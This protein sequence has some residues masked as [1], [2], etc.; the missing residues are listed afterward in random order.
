MRIALVGA[1]AFDSLEYNLQETFVHMG[2]E[3]FV[4]NERQVVPL[5]GRASRNV[6]AVASS[7]GLAPARW[8]YDRLVAKVIAYSP[9]LTV[10]T[11]R[12]LPPRFVEGLKEAIPKIP[13]VQINPDAI[14]GVERGYI[15]LSPFDAYFT[16]EP[17]LYL[18][19]KEKLCL[20]AHYLPESFN[21]RVHTKPVLPKPEC[22]AR[23]NVDLVVVATLYP[24]RIRFLE[25]L[26]SLLP[27][28]IRLQ[29]YGGKRSWAPTRLWDHHTGRSLSGPEKA[30]VFYGARVV[31]NNMHFAEADGV[32]CRFFEVLGSG[33]F[34]LCDDKPAVADLATPGTEVVTFRSVKEAAEKIQYYLAHPE[35]R[36]A[37]A[38]A[39]YERAIRSH[40][41]EHRI[42]SVLSL[43][44]MA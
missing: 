13:V 9:D 12:H 18:T 8:A 44:G 27:S 7:L 16:K 42:Q 34:M 14:T 21:P 24:Y 26:M 37:I 23:S 33:A 5:F 43:L 19:M 41:Y 38:Q 31:L 39:A 20:N 17:Q 40:T 15:F 29:I 10:V 30:D 28:R 1:E 11:Y 36:W 3:A 35:E 2:H 25:K 32:N 6:L 4:F 22:E